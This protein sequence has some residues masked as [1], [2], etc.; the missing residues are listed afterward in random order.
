MVGYYAKNVRL[1][2]LGEGVDHL[3]DTVRMIY[4]HSLI[5]FGRT[6]RTGPFCLR[7]EQVI[8]VT[9]GKASK[10]GRNSDKGTIVTGFCKQH[11]SRFMPS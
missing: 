4:V 8:G 10:Y 9:K 2:N 1:A 7:R 5:R 6:G 3:T 11:Q